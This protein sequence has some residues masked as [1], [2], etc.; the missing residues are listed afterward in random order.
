MNIRDVLLYHAQKYPQMQVQDAVKLIY[1]NEFGAGHMIKDKES[2]RARLVAELEST[3]TN[4]TLSLTEP[5]GNG[6]VRVNLAAL[7]H[8]RVDYNTVLDAF[9]MTGTFI[10]GGLDSFLEKTSV[11]RELTKEGVFSFNSATLSEYLE[12]YLKLA[13]KDGKLPPVSHSEQYRAAYAPAY[14]VVALRFIQP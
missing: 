3:P 1:Q 2:A 14:R 9:V 7:T 6:M 5:L 12:K 8:Y 11:L 13:D 4:P 10:S